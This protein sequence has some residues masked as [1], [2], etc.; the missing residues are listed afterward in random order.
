VV[1]A[2][3]HVRVQIRIDEHRGEQIRRAMD[4]NLVGLVRLLRLVRP[5]V[6]LTA[7]AGIEILIRSQ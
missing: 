2:H 1:D 3:P 6:N 4:V 5:R 7:G